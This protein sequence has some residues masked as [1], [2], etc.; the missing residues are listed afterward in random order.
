M[1]SVGDDMP[2]DFIPQREGTPTVRE[3]PNRGK[4]KGEWRKNS[5]S[6]D[7]EGEEYLGGK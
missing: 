2:N 1:A 3:H 7:L 4:G 6:G 5:A